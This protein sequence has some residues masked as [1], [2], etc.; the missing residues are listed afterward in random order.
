M[1]VP[2]AR[3]THPNEPMRNCTPLPSADDLRAAFNYNPATGEITN[4]VR[5][6]NALAGS[7]AGSQRK[8][9]YV[10]IL[11]NYK[12]YLGHRI[13]WKIYTGTEPPV[14]IDHLNRNPSDNRWCNLRASDPL[15]NQGNRLSGRGLNLAGTKRN[16][17]R[18]CAK[19]VEGHLGQFDTEQEA[20]TAYV[21]WHKSYFGE[22]SIYAAS[23]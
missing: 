4:K 16:G 17:K 3:S 11:F 15:K 14:H 18:W 22:H 21:K 2:R 13:A 5:R 9:G 1:P 23:S 12:K 7:K 19:C 8:D 20:H 10:Q 6:G